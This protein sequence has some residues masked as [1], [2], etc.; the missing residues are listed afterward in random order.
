[1]RQLV[2]GPTEAEEVKSRKGK[3]G[4]GGRVGCRETAARIEA[5]VNIC[6]AIAV[7]A[8]KKGSSLDLLRLVASV[9]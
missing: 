6:C 2:D 7:A 1:M 3:E 9:L 5:A 4:R 8:K